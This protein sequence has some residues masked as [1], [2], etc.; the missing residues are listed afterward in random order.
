MILPAIMSII[1]I[2]H[3]LYN[4]KKCA[5]ATSRTANYGSAKTPF[6]LYMVKPLAPQPPALVG[7]C[8]RRRN[9]HVRTQSYMVRQWHSH[10]RHRLLL[11][12]TCYL[13]SCSSYTCNIIDL[14]NII[15]TYVTHV[16]ITRYNDSSAHMSVH[17]VTV[18]RSHPHSH[19][20]DAYIMYQSLQ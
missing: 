17:S 14:T 6:I 5:R 16:R 15:A 8:D 2:V 3:Q 1:C 11:F 7:D 9:Y 12:K 10:T 4:T 20:C 19:T 18:S 13:A